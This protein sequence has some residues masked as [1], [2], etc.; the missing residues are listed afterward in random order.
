M[1][2]TISYL[3][4]SN[5]ESVIL[6]DSRDVSNFLLVKERWRIGLY[7]EVMNYPDTIGSSTGV[8]E[9]AARI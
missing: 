4:D 3:L 5:P 7:I 8:Y 9:S 1:V 6:L 2:S